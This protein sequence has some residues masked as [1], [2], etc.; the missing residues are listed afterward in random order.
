MDEIAKF[1]EQHSAGPQ[2]IGFDYQFYYFVMLILELKTGQ[3]I[4]FEIKDDIH[5]EKADGTIVL[6]QAKHTV[7]KKADGTSEN[8]TALDA[9]LWKT[10]SNWTNLVKLNHEILK[11]HLFCLVRTKVKRLTNFLKHWR[12]SKARVIPSNC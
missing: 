7:A 8:L 11:N 1:Q 4:G 5:I 6:F 3:K 12:Y 10:L 9:D 2:A